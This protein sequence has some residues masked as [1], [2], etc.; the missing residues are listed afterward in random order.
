MDRTLFNSSRPNLEHLEDRLVP[1]TMAGNYTDG[2]WRYDDIAGWAHIS[3][4]KA[5][6]LDVDDA[7][8]VYGKFADGLWRWQASTAS[9]MKLSN[10]SDQQFQ[11]TGSGILYGDFGTVGTWRWSLSD[12]WMRLTNNDVTLMAVSDSDTFFGRYDT[13]TVGTWRW[14]PTAGWS[15]LSSN[16]PDQLQADDA[17]NLV[18]VYNNYISATQKGTWR[19]NPTIG[20]ERLST[21][22]PLAID[23]SDNGTVFENRGAG[24]LWRWTP[25][26]NMF[27]EISSANMHTAS[28]LF[29]LPDGSLYLDF[30]NGSGAT[31]RYNGWYWNAGTGWVEIFPDSTNIYPAV[32]GKDGDI[33]LD[34]STGGT[35]QW[36][37]SIA[38]HQIGIL[39]PTFLASQS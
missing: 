19:W 15:I 30:D 9:W 20:W 28:T 8:D 36:G 12:G 6:Q 17:G 7:G 34:H 18:G 10:L 16:R 35:W 13:G 11:V 14:T 32:V 5:S 31:P 25:A 27:T 1:S 38:A 23:V 22:A 21:A 2:V 3:V 33:Y 24:G 4:N 39:D 26:S 37:P 29:A